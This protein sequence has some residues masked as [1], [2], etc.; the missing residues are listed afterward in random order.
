MTDN[1]ER[2]AASIVDS[3][4]FEHL[5]PEQRPTPVGLQGVDSETVEPHSPSAPAYGLT[6]RI[7]LMLQRAFE[8]ELDYYRRI[9]SR[10][11]G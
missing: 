4:T 11:G 10:D 1:R 7:R 2:S 9:V 3:E 5:P 8:A 6:K